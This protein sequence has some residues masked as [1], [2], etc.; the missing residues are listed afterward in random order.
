M[1][2][3]WLGLM[4]EAVSAFGTVGL[5]TGVTAL[6]TSGGK[7]VI[8]LLMFL[9]RVGPLVLAVYLARPV[10]PWHIR[11]PEEDVSLG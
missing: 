8:M 7:V 9:G 2:D 3:G 4:F 11:Y 5:S 6:L 10:H 1:S